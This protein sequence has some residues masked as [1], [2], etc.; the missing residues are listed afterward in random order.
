[1]SDERSRS[2]WRWRRVR[3]LALVS[4]LVLVAAAVAFGLL[5]YQAARV[6][7]HRNEEVKAGLGTIRA[8]VSVWTMDHG[9][10]WP[11]EQLVAPSG[12]RPFLPKGV[13]WPVNPFTGRPTHP[14]TSPG[15]YR[16][17][18][19]RDSDGGKVV[20]FSLEGFNGRGRLI[21]P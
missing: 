10:V 11:P 5:K 7:S 14:G 21:E 18:V 12:L 15:D 8:A 13:S 17:S 19:V 16:Y 3:V 2:V 4:V 9:R 20:G 1:M 6:E